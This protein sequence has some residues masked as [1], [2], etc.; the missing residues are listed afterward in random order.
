[1]LFGERGFL[2]VIFRGFLSLYGCLVLHSFLEGGS[3]YSSFIETKEVERLILKVGSINVC[4]LSCQ[5]YYTYETC[6]HFA[7]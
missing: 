3:I 2:S 4:L 1:M 5:F 6:E 7:L